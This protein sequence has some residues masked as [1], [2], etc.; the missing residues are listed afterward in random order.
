MFRIIKVDIFCTDILIS[1]NQSD[2]DLFSCLCEK[3]TSEQFGEAFG[4][5]KSHARTVTHSDG[6]ILIRFKNKIN[7]S[8][9]MIGLVSHE[10][11]H[12]AYSMLSRI[13]IEPCYETEEVY[14]YVTQYIVTEIFK[15]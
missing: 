10:A 8:P 1:S 6:F 9:E 3:F 4:D 7:K 15:L 13:G 2:K 12:A 11:Y 5:F 14:A